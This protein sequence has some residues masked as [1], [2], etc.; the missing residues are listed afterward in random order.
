ME[1]LSL[2]SDAAELRLLLEVTNYAASAISGTV[3]VEISGLGSC[4]IKGQIEAH[5]TEQWL[6]DSSDCSIL[7]VEN[8]LIWWPAQ[9]GTP[10][11]YF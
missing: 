8:P 1:T 10:S 6:Y 9:M 7:S 11:I 4:E 2:Y 5:A 3:S